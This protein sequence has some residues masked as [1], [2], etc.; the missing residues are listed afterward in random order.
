MKSEN[1]YQKQYQDIISE[2]F[3]GETAPINGESYPIHF[4][5]ANKDPILQKQA[6]ID[7]AKNKIL[8]ETNVIAEADEEIQGLK[9]PRRRRIRY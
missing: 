8:H 7:D 3:I 2:E 4:G 1:P 6:K 9:K 5:N